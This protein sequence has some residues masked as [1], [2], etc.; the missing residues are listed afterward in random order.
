MQ[1]QVSARERARDSPIAHEPASG[2]PW[3]P[4]GW[5]TTVLVAGTSAMIEGVLWC[6]DRASAGAAAS[7]SSPTLPA[8]H[9]LP[10]RRVISFYVLPGLVS[11][12]LLYGLK[13]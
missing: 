3:D 7:R 9:T 13:R 2:V 1:R 8:S 4:R 12:Q 11:N 10:V 6:A 5:K